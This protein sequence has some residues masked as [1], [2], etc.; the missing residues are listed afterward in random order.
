MFVYSLACKM[1][2]NDFLHIG[3]VS[4]SGSMET[5]TTQERKKMHKSPEVQRLTQFIRTLL[6][7][8]DSVNN[9]WGKG[10]FPMCP[11]TTRCTESSR[12]AAFLRHHT[13]WGKHFGEAA[14]SESSML[15]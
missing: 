15:L 9:W 11:V 6:K 14:T 8:I 13:L 4:A 12:D 7:E 5:H 1:L 10:D 2:Y 3:T